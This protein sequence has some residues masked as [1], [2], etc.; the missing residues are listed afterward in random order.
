[1]EYQI[2]GNTNLIIE[3]K[4]QNIDDVLMNRS[5][6]I[7]ENTNQNNISFQSNDLVQDNC[8]NKAIKNVLDMSISDQGSQDST[9]KTNN[10]NIFDF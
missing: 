9:K 10:E 8:S 1:M 7:N 2:F 5:F 3:G 6:S 4:N